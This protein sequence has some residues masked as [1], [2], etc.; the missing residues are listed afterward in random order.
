M[1]DW[2][3]GILPFF[4]VW[5]LEMMKKKTKVLVAC[6][7]AFAAMYVTHILSLHQYANKSSVEVPVLLFAWA[8]FI[9]LSTALTFSVRI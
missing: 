7:L 9:H 5:G 2:V 4:I 1:A 6:I 3:L 8:T